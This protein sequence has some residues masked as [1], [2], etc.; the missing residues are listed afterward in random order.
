MIRWIWDD[1]GMSW[2]DR[3]NPQLHA[4]SAIRQ[5]WPWF[6]ALRTL[7]DHELLL[8]G[9]G[10][11]GRI[12]WDG[13]VVPVR[14]SSWVLIPPGQPHTCHGTAS[15]AWR[16]WVHFDWEHGPAL[17]PLMTYAPSRAPERVLRRAPAWVPLRGVASGQIRDLPEAR[18]LHGRIAAAWAHGGARRRSFGRGLLLELLLRLL[19]PEDGEPVDRGQALAVRVRDALDAIAA[20]PFARADALRTALARLGRSPDHAARAFRS[21]FGVA[22][23]RYLAL[24][25]MRRAQELL[26][27]GMRAATVARELGFADAGYFN[28]VFRRVTGTA[29]ARW[30]A[31]ATTR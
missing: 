16:A 15:A 11:D 2:L 13:G 26:L 19:A 31:D 21:V 24:Q 3:C 29:P 25:R 8:F 30:A 22:P 7:H 14:G 23:A 6:D 10:Y 12:A 9:P 20:Q 4:A 18:D 27:T 17:S 5:R 1:S 28:R